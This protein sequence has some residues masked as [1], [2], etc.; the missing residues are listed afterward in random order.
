VAA[1]QGNERSLLWLYR[2]LMMLRRAEPAL[3][4]GDYIPLRSRHDVLTFKRQSNGTQLLVA[5]NMVSEPRRFVWQD[6]G[7]LLLTSHLDREGG[8]SPT[9]LRVDEG[10]VVR[11]AL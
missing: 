7:T 3:V 4:E 6:K 11:C 2:R 9:M 1:L 8:A 5:L 10:V